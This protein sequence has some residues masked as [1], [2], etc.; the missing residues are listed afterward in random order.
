MSSRNLNKRAKITSKFP[1]MLTLQQSLE[2]ALACAVFSGDLKSLSPRMNNLFR[3]IPLSLEDRIHE[4]IKVL[5]FPG[6]KTKR[7]LARCFHSF[8]RFSKG[9]ICSKSPISTGRNGQLRPGESLNLIGH[10]GNK[11]RQIS[12]P[13]L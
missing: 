13:L 1:Y 3:W 9:A 6:I 7:S 2:H 10:I 12:I 8:S 5:L 4:C 11:T